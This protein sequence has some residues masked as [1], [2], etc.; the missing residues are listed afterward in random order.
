MAA[1]H[2]MAPP[3]RGG[4]GVD[5]R[6]ASMAGPAEIDEYKVCFDGTHRARLP[7]DTLRALE[8]IL[9]QVGITR[10]ADVT[11]LDE[12]G[13]PVYQAIRPDSWSLCVSQGKGLTGDLAKVSAVME[14]I[15]LWHAE[16]MPAGKVLA[17]PR[18]LASELGYRVEELPLA[19]RSALCPDM[20]I[21][22]SQATEIGTGERTWL[23]SDLLNMD[24]RTGSR[25]CMPL[26]EKST[27]GL[28]S[29]NTLTEA[30]LHG[31]YEVVERDALAGSGAGTGASV[32]VLDSVAG[33]AEE[34][35]DQLRRAGVDVRVALLPSP[36]G[37]PCF[38][39]K[40]WSD[41]LPIVF[42]GAGCHLD[43]DVALCRALTEAAQSRLTMI[44][45]TRDDMTESEYH[46]AEGVVSGRLRPPDFA[47]LADGTRKVAHAD[48][49]TVQQPDL[50]EDLR[51]T[52]DRVKAVTG[53]EPLYVDH[54]RPEPGVPV[55]HV[56]CPGMRFDPRH[57]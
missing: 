48:V 13:I 30:L 26:F 53:R 54:T 25:W 39:A 42:S 3:P 29:G 5:S 7:Q 2:G 23:P 22:W 56:V 27:N 19:R 32:L 37:L 17:S 36:A 52:A 41:G 18:E 14:S 24:G 20:R 31:L 9:D 49:P 34:L 57:S 16:R 6:K 40:I 15:E 1:A 44:S 33:P 45:G 8:P 46:R 28:A 51:M 55:V 21:E 47:A 35:I 10:I 50:V 4:H 12:I 38:Q 11:W 43:R